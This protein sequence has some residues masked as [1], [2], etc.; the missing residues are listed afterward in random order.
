MGNTEL[1]LNEKIIA[2]REKHDLSQNKMAEAAAIKFRT[3]QNIEYGRTQSIS[4]EDALKLSLAFGIRLGELLEDTEYNKYI[5]A[6]ENAPSMSPEQEALVALVLR[7]P[8]ERI[9]SLTKTV[10]R[11]INKTASDQGESGPTR[12]S[13]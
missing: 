8:K 10:E 9:P 4:L 12:D 5:K 13:K 1:S 2:L 11:L 6:V 3:Y 7:V